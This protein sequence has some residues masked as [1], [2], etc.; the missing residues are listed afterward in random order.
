[1]RFY[2]TGGLGEGRRQQSQQQQGQ[3]HEWNGKPGSHGRVGRKW[4]GWTKGKLGPILRL[5]GR[6]EMKLSIKFKLTFS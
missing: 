6:F 2:G 3:G 4:K 5:N 1:V